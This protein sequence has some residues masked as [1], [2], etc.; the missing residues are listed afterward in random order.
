ML[1]DKNIVLAV[2][3]SIAAYK[4]ANVASA[5]VKQHANVTVMMTQNATN[6][7]NPIT[8]ETL[9]GNKCL[10]DT[11][12]RNF[13]YSV[14]HVALANSAD[15]V[16]IAPATAN[17]IA[18]LAN[19]LADDMLTTTVLACRCKKIVSPAMNT[20]MFE[21]PITQYNIDKLK[22]FGF[23]II[24][25]ASGRLACGDVGAGKLPAEE[26]LLDYIYKEIMFDKILSGKKVLVTAGPTK[27]AL[28]PVRYI[29]NH[30][31]GKMGYSLAKVASYMG[32]E[33]TLVSGPVALQSPNFVNCVK[34]VSAKD[35]YEA[36]MSK[37][38]ETDIIIMAAAVAD[39]TSPVVADSKI[40]KKDQDMSISLAR[41]KDILATLGEKKH[42]K[43]FLCGFSMETDNLLDNS[44]AKLVKKNADMIVANSLRDAGAGFGTDTNIVTLITRDGAETLPI[45]SKDK[46]SAKILEDIVKR[47]N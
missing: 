19:G 4:M 29:S 11:F 43:Q 31:T 46:V 27:E 17:V 13:Q 44:S 8:F 7:I 33:V 24:E 23:E 39:Y 42:E 10:V 1:K 38:D 47:M 5:L 6:F 45:M 30:S 22:K 40:K 32:A 9:T 12:D 35:M 37:A 34:V 41:T 2:T 3:G 21:N 28:D 26:I 16:L 14:E 20:N 36:V 18:K 15:V 25:P